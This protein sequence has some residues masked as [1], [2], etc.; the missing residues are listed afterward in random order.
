MPPQHVL[1]GLTVSGELTVGDL[2]VGAGT[3]LLAFFTWRL[4]RQARADV[5]MSSRSVEA[6]DIPFLVAHPARPF[7]DLSP[8]FDEQGEEVGTNPAIAFKMTN[9]GRGP[10]FFYGA[11]LSG[12]DGKEW[13]EGLWSREIDLLPGDE[14][15]T[16]VVDLVDSLEHP[17][18]EP[19][20][21]MTLRIFYRSALA[22]E[23]ETV[24]KLRFDSAIAVTR[25]TFQ[26]NRLD[27]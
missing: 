21:E 14:S 15:T 11:R 26:R 12:S 3:L 4:A 17:P 6:V 7:P 8:I 1:L 16:L 23:Y 10:G 20:T 9:M 25:L 19:G 13:V 18:Q 27:N 5:N 22:Y 2:V 24:H